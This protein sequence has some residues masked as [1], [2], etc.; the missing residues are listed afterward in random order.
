M[1]SCMYW[2]ELRLAKGCVIGEVH[3]LVGPILLLSA[4]F[5][6]HESTLPKLRLLIWE[7]ESRVDP[8]LSREAILVGVVFESNL[9]FMAL[10]FLYLPLQVN[11]LLFVPVLL[12]HATHRN[13]TICPRLWKLVCSPNLFWIGRFGTWVP[14]F[15]FREMLRKIIEKLIVIC[16]SF[17]P[18]F[19]PS[20]SELYIRRIIAFAEVFVIRFQCW[21]YN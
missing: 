19:G 1:L 8:I 20:P 5:R 15:S 4:S 16:I 2:A 11:D 14:C 18:D 21:R 7:C 17:I 9:L 10:K 3:V 13:L 12:A 6:I